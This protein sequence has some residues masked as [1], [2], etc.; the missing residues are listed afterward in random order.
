MRANLED[1][2]AR[3]LRL[4]AANFSTIEAIITSAYRISPDGPQFFYLNPLG[5]TLDVFLP[6]IAKGGGQFYLITNTSISA[7][8]LNIRDGG[9]VL[10]RNVTSGTTNVIISSNISWHISS[11]SNVALGS[12]P[13]GAF[14]VF[15]DP[16]NGLVARPIVSSD[17][18][19]AMNTAIGGVK[20]VP[21]VTGRVLGSLDEGGAFVTVASREVLL[22]N[23]TYFV[24]AARPDDSGDGLTSGTAWKTLQH[25]I[26][27]VAS[28]D[29]SAFNVTI[30]VAAGTY[31][32][33]LNLKSYVGAGPVV[34]LGAALPTTIIS[35]INGACIG[36]NG[37]I[38]RWVFDNFR[39]TNTGAA[40][41]CV[42]VIRASQVDFQLGVEFGPSPGAHISL[43][44]TALV[45]I[46]CPVTINGGAT[47][48]V[49]AAANC[50]F[51]CAG[52]AISLA[53][54]LTFA[55]GFLQATQGGIISYNNNTFPGAGGITATGP[56]AIVTSNAVID[57]GK[58]TNAAA[59]AYLP[60]DHTFTESSGGVL[61]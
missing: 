54:G 3:K 48:H 30:N 49:S 55:N 53:A 9:G 42:S 15:N 38:G 6:P 32:Q 11:L 43:T 14:F 7:G 33:A 35:T 4:S 61:I 2:L 52:R 50:T 26:D 28:I 23:R 41:P 13:G 58:G 44:N 8:S 59:A 17:I 46:T 16:V 60:G 1:N 19:A 20:A 45:N 36:A 25:A 47:Q 39:L 37:V 57:T 10:L 40:F 29:L 5:S 34:F 31:T 22:A 21:F 51:A 27:V 24:D 56:S 12:I 18:P